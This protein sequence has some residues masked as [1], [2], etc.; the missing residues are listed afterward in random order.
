MS[1]MTGGSPEGSG[2]EPPMGWGGPGDIAVI[3]D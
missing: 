3:L 2:D 1:V